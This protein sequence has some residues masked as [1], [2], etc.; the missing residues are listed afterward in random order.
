MGNEVYFSGNYMCP[1]GRSDAIGF[2]IDP[3][4][5]GF[6]TQFG[7]LIGFGGSTL[8]S[9]VRTGPATFTKASRI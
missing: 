6:A 2:Y 3:T 9:A 4:P 1:N 5:D 8:L 7:G